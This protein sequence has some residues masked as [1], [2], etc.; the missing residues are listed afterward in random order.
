MHIQ[1][2]FHIISVIVSL[3]LC[4]DEHFIFVKHFQLH[5]LYEMYD[6]NKVCLHMWNDMSHM[7]HI[8]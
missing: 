8:K 6:T 7:F 2:L 4:R 3:F 1:L 5:V